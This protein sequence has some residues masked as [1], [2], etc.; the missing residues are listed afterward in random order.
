MKTVPLCCPLLRVTA[1]PYTCVALCVKA[2][3]CEVNLSWSAS[4]HS[5]RSAFMAKELGNGKMVTHHMQK[6]FQM[7]L[8]KIR[9]C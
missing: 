4:V 8:L 3:V 2:Q 5:R 7:F 6:L 9:S 1:V